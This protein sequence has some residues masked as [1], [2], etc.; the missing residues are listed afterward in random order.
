[1][2]FTGIGFIFQTGYPETSLRDT[3]SLFCIHFS[4]E[5]FLCGGFQS[6]GNNVGILFICYDL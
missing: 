4:C 5:F 6:A 1:M 3:L 2:P